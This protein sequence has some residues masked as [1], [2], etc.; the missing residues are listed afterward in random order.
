VR[1]YFDEQAIRHVGGCFRDRQPQLLQTSF[2]VAGLQL[3]IADT[4]CATI[5]S[6]F[7]LGT[8]TD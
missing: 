4:A 6:S 1:N 2:G 7:A 3:L 8:A 5:I